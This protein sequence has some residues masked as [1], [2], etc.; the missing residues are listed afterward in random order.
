MAMQHII[1]KNGFTE[2][3]KIDLS[4]MGAELMG[5]KDYAYE[6]VTAHVKT[7]HLVQTTPA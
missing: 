5:V 4:D 6:R 7:E 3:G 2:T 1:K